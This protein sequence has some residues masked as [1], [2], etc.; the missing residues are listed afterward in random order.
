MFGAS[1]ETHLITLSRTPLSK[2]IFHTQRA[3]RKKRERY[4]A[5]L[6]TVEILK[7][8]DPYERSKLGD[9]LKEERFAANDFV[10]KEGQAGDRFFIIQ[11]GTA[12]ATKVLQE[13]QPPQQVM[14]YA[15]GMYFGERALL[16]NEARAAN[17]IATSDLHL[18]SLE[19]ETF[20]RLLG[21]LDSLLMRN[22]DV[23][24]KFQK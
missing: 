1:I 21:P 3:F 10:I 11:E 7:T 15:K 20:V 9:A 23:Y 16:K 19:R 2:S 4:D 12:I 6:Q 24:N 13:G 14:E 8:M 5:F 17:V 22:M 18:L